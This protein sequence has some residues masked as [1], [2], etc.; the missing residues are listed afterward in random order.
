[1]KFLIDNWYLILA[2]LVSGGLL[3]W[4]TLRR[5]GAA[6]T[7]AQAVQLINR[8]RAVLI[9]VRE[10]EEFAKGHAAGSRN[11]PL[12]T[13]EGDKSLPKNK[14]LPIVLICAS[15]ARANRAAGILAKLGYEK[16]QALAGGFPAWREANLPVEKS[17]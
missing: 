14:T 7:P 8:E 5:G 3:L 1:L 4:P 6:L 11:A 12:A 17:A 13:L 10:A 15:G 9:D 16:A 2:A